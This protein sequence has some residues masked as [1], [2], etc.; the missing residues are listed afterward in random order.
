MKSVDRIRV[1]TAARWLE[2]LGEIDGWRDVLADRFMQEINEGDLYY[3]GLV[4]PQELRESSRE[5]FDFLLAE[6][7][8]RA[9]T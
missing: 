1:T 7:R 8:R 2:L 4:K 5:A 6:L 9:A 3:E